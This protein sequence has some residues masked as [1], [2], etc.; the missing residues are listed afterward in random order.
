MELETQ[1]ALAR[2]FLSLWRV[3]MDDAASLDGAQVQ[4]LIDAT[5]LVVE[6]P[7]TA[8]QVALSNA[9]LEVGDSIIVLNDEGKR[10]IDIALGKPEVD[11][12]PP[13]V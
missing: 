13:T 9:D 5:G 6:V 2:L 11:A 1:A 12:G 4:D 7:A 8:E 10:V 3:F